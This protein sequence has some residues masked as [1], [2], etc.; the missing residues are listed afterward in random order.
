MLKKFFKSNFIRRTLTA[1]TLAPIVLYVTYL[2]G[3]YFV[4]FLLL[5]LCLSLFEF[6]SIIFLNNTVGR[7]SKFLWSI[8][9]LLYICLAVHSLYFIR[10]NGYLHYHVFALFF[11]IWIFDSGAYLIGSIIGGP[12]LIPKISP[13][14]TW[15]GLFG[16]IFFTAA[17]SLAY[18]LIFTTFYTALND[19]LK[20]L[21][22]SDTLLMW[23][24]IAL[25]SET[26]A[27]VGQVGDLIQSYFKRKFSVKDSGYLLPGHGGILDRMDSI[28]LASIFLFILLGF[29]V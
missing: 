13:R 27:L 7:R 9:G 4:A 29:T 15:S 21:F 20:N 19:K 25:W 17:S 26:L 18:C 1:L 5:V 16:G 28:F 14:K 24:T 6:F 8:I 3:S 12:K 10:K 23:I 22:V 11:S 2:G